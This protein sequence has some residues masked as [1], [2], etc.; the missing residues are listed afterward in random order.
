MPE[1]K[2]EDLDALAQ[3]LYLEQM[4]KVSNMKAL[5]PEEIKPLEDIRRSK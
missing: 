3:K 5:S 2:I 4:K 1:V